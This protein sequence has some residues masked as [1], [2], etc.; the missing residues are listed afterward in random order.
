MKLREKE[1]LLL[2]YGLLSWE[3][4]RK[5]ILLRDLPDGITCTICVANF[6]YQKLRGAYQI[7]IRV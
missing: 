4:S 3:D 5:I 6:C 1:I 2:Y 7:H